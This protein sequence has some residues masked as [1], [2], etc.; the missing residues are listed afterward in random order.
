MIALSNAYAAN[1]QGAKAIEM[2][3]NLEERYPNNPDVIYSLA[4][5]NIQGRNYQKAIGHLERYITIDPNNPEILDK[6]GRAYRSM[7]KFSMAQELF[8][9]SL[10]NQE[11]NSATTG[12][13]T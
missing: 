6:A 8:N 2:L 4:L 10:E 5:A 12:G 7:N 13:N 3:H 1:G 9:A 11:R